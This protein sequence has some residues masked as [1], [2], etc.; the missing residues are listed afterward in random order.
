MNYS[1]EDI[2]ALVQA[3]LQQAQK[4]LEAGELLFEQNFYADSINRFYYSM[5]YAVLALLVTRQLG[6]SKHKGAIA[7]FDREFVKTGVFSKQMSAGL[8][9]A[10]E[11]RLEADYA[12]LVDSSIDD[13]RECLSYAEDFLSQVREYLQ[14]S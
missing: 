4:A 11:Q 1:E 7:L 13:A 6:T 12:D 14:G 3:R 10:F 8:H 2:S 5:F 9:F